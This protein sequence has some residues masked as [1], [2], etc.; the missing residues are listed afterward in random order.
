MEYVKAEVMGQYTQLK[1]LV[2]NPHQVRF[3]GPG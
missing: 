3:T 2:R 1:E